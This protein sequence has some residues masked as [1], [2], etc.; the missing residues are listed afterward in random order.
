MTELNPRSEERI[1]DAIIEQATHWYVRN[2]DC[3]L[4]DAEK[5]DFL[6][7]LRTSPQHTSEYLQISGLSGGIRAAIRDLK[8]HKTRFVDHT[9]SNINDTVVAFA[10]GHGPRPLRRTLWRVFGRPWLAGFA[11][12]A[13][14]VCLVGVYWFMPPGFAGL[15][16]I[17]SV[18]HGEQ[19]TVSLSDGSVVHVNASSEIIVRFSKN[20]RLVDLAHGQAMFEVAHNATRPFRVRAGATEVIA[21]GTQ[22]DVYRH[23]P[24]GVTVTVVEGKVDIVNLEAASHPKES[25][26]DTTTHPPLRL[27][28]GEQVQM[29]SA[30]QGEQPKSID[31][32]AATAWV[33][34]EIMIES[35]P[36]G[37]VAAEINRY[38]S[39][40]IEID[41]D[42]L[43]GM[44][45]SGV[46]DAYD[47]ESFLVFLRQ[48]DV[49]IEEGSDS[50]RV[51][52][53]TLR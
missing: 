20:E 47:S 5:T 16:R 8:L 27:R 21:V 13:V 41:D 4:T 6:T 36:L 48:Y 30:R 35:Q 28:A 24:E 12:A 46:F 3:A 53:R 1:R 22:F 2:R 25:G 34:R 14:L 26:P 42:T 9:A 19:R 43:K 10:P 15:P 31:I 52:A 50:I 23:D 40:P 7:W 45:V 17:I 11:A 49:E 39:K 32:R 44:R 38:V 29:G 33:R 37:N 18:A 51:R